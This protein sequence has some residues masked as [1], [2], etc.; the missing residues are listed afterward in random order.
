M[1]FYMVA[2]REMPDEALVPA[3]IVL[4]NATFDRVAAMVENPPQATRALR[5]M[6]RDRDD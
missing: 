1:L 4:E 3:R 6:M 5:E 2:R